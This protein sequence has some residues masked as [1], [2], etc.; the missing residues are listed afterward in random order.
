MPT[1][2]CAARAKV[3]SRRWMA[4]RHSIADQQL[5]QVR[6]AFASLRAVSHAALTLSGLI[7]PCWNSIVP[8]RPPPKVGAST[9]LVSGS[10]Y[11]VRFAIG[12]GTAMTL[13]LKMLALSIILGLVQIVLASHASS[14]QRGYIW[15]ASSR[16]EAVP[17]LTG[18]AGRLARALQ[19]SS[20]RFRCSLQPSW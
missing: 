11:R 19:N 16:D 12:I 9:P 13:E 6:T 7:G 4:G 5:L 3:T 8:L 17:A 15:T 20:R 2:L 10:G 1:P 18:V 14:L